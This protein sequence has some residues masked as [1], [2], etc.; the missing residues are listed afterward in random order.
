[1]SSPPHRTASPSLE[2][3]V[4]FLPVGPGYQPPPSSSHSHEGALVGLAGDLLGM[5]R[6]NRHSPC[7]V[8]LASLL[9][10]QKYK[11]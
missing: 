8:S 9:K 6:M 10:T 4:P 11:E 1:M 2:R 7:D 5:M 3:L